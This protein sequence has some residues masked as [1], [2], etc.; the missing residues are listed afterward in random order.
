M[1]LQPKSV[2]IIYRKGVRDMN[3]VIIVISL[4]TAVI[5]LA[6]ALLLYKA[7]KK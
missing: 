4:V 6:T 7:S 5:N 1:T 2:I 3:E